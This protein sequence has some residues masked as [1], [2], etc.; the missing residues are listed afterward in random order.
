MKK[1][2]KPGPGLKKVSFS[3]GQM[4]LELLWLVLFVCGFL[5]VLC[6]LYESGNRQINHSQKGLQWPYKNPSGK[7]FKQ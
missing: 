5:A 1:P 4:V 2:L 6:H 7:I 3:K